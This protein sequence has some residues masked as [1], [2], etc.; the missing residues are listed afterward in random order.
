MN[1]CV[2]GRAASRCDPR[3]DPMAAAMRVLEAFAA[4]QT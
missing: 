1:A 3:L 2:A 4:E